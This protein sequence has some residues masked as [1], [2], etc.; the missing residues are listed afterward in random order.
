M[1]KIIWKDVCHVKINY[2]KT[3]MKAKYQYHVCKKIELFKL[4]LC[5]YWKITVFSLFNRSYS[6]H[7]EKTMEPY[8]LPPLK[9]KISDQTFNYPDF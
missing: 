6:F 3:N 1:K 7:N 9:M 8:I 2:I 5:Y 4:Y